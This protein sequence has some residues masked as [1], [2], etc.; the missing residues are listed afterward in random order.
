MTNWSSTLPQ[1]VRTLFPEGV[2]PDPSLVTSSLLTTVTVDNTNLTFSYVQSGS[3]S[4]NR[5]GFAKYNPSLQ[6]VFSTSVQYAFPKI[7]SLN[8]GCLQY[9]DTYTFGPFLNGD[10]VIMFLDA[11]SEST[12]RYWS[13]IDLPGW[14]NPDGYTHSAWVYLTAENMVIFGMEDMSLGDAD[15][16][17]VM[18]Y[19]SYQGAASFGQVA[20]YTNGAIQ[21]C[22]SNTAVSANS[23]AEL[24][25]TQWGLLEPTVATQSCLSFLSIPSG[26]TWASDSDPAAHAAITQLGS[27]QWTYSAATCFLLSTGSATG[28]GYTASGAACDPTLYS[29]KTLANSAGGLCYNAAC[30]SRYVLRGADLG[31]SCTARGVCSSTET[32]TV[33]STIPVNSS[34]VVDFPGSYSVYIP[35]PSGTVN[36]STTIQI[37]AGKPEVDIFVLL[38]LTTATTVPGIANSFT[39]ILS[40]LNGHGLNANVGL[41]IYTP[42]SSA[43]YYVVNSNYTLTGDLQA[44]NAWSRANIATATWQATCPAVGVG[45]SP[46]YSAM[47]SILD[48]ARGLNWRPDAFHLMWVVSSCSFDETMDMRQAVINTG[49]MPLFT[50]P[51]ANDYPSGWDLNAPYSAPYSLR[52]KAGSSKTTFQSDVFRDIMSDDTA[53][54]GPQLIASLWALAFPYVVS[55]PNG[56]ITNLPT[57]P[58]WIGDPRSISVNYTVAWPNGMVPDQSVTSYHSTIRMIGRKVTTI[59]INFNHFPVLSDI[60]MPINAGTNKTINFNP[61]DSDGNLVGLVVVSLP[62]KGV[63]YRPDTGAAITAAGTALPYGMNSLIYYAYPRT[64]GPDTWHMGARD[65]CSIVYAN[66]TMIISY[67]NTP[68][69]AID[70]SITMLEDSLATGTNGLIDFSSHISDLD[71]PA[72]GQTLQVFLSSLPSP[73]NYGSLTTWSASGAGTAIT[74]LGAVANQ[75]R[76]VLNLP[77]GFGSASFYYKVNDGIADSN[78]AKVTINIVHVNHAPVLNI[79][80]TQFNVDS[81]STANVA[82]TASITDSDGSLDT[83]NLYAVWS[84]VTTF[85]VQTAD[86]TIPASPSPTDASPF[87]MYN[88]AYGPSSG[89]TFP[90]PGLVW[91]H[92]TATQTQ[93]VTFQA[94]DNSGA[95]SNNVTVYFSVTVVSAPSSTPVAATPNP[96]TWTLRPQDA[97]PSGFT[98]SQ[99][100]S[101]NLLDFAATDIDAGEYQTLIFTLQSKSSNGDV[102]LVSQTSPSS[103]ISLSAGTDFSDPLNTATYVPLNSSALTSFFRFSYVP[104]PTFYG[105]DQFVVVVRDSTNLYAST[106]ANVTVQVVRLDT[107]PLSSNSYMRGDE[108]AIVMTSIPLFSTNSPSNPVQLQLLSSSF[109][110]L[111]SLNSGLATPWTPGQNTTLTTSGFVSVY[112]QGLIGMFSPNATV[113]IGSFTYRVLEPETADSAV[114]PTYTCQ[115]Y[116]NHVNHPPTSSNVAYTVKKRTV[117]QIVLPAMDPDADDTP[118]TITAVLK[119]IAS[120]SQGTFYLDAGLTQVI[121]NNFISS[122]VTA[123]SLGTART[124]YYVSNTAYSVP[125]NQP[126]ARFTFIVVDQHGLPSESTYTGAITVLPAGDA[127]VYGGLLDVT[128]AQ[129]M[130]VSMALNVGVTT[131]TGVAA[132][133]TIQTLPGRG[134]L[135]ACD[136]SSI[137]CTAVSSSQLPLT[138]TSSNGRVIFLPRAYDWDQNFTSFNFALTDSSNPAAVSVWTMR[139]HVIH[140]NKNPFIE[141]SNFLTTSQTTA[142]IVVNES[143][144]HTFTWKTYDQDSLP[145]VLLTSLRISFYTSQGFTLYSCTG[146][147]A[148]WAVD[149]ECVFNPSV[150]IG[151]RTAFSKNAKQVIGSYST[152]S[153][154]CPDFPTLKAKYGAIDSNCEAHFKMAFVPTPG[155]SFTPYISINFNAVDDYGAESQTISALIFV[156]RMNQPPTLYTPPLVLGSSGV[157]NP[158]IRNTDQQSAQFNSPVIVGD[159][160][161]FGNAELLTVS[162]NQGYAGALFWPDIAPCWAD[163]S[164]NAQVWYCKDTIPSFNQWLSDLRF[165]VDSGNRA[166]LTFTFN[167]LGYSSDWKPSPNITVSSQTSIRLYAAITAPKGNSSTLAISVGIAAGAGLILLGALGFIL[168]RAVSPPKD[169]YFSDAIAPLNSSPTSPLYQA[170]NETHENALYKSKV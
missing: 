54:G 136:A 66:A 85:T 145:S 39:A 81:T 106:V 45:R 156:K 70:F 110:G 8:G 134:T 144:S 57:S 117:L 89:T 160:D 69:V 80:I 32:G 91:N 87:A 5:L 150:P 50:Y 130:P 27:T 19:L 20:P 92:N 34:N 43:P 10:L 61:S 11:D 90:V 76:F 78:L 152:V 107:P 95:K 37:P 56:F 62:L 42:I 94:R 60:T 155:S 100:S 148:N 163:P 139:I 38:D 138:L 3:G 26:W 33:I 147:P 119:S 41:A 63:L 17:D 164:P 113:P 143:T 167:D 77:S 126:L 29:I 4:T 84:S 158:F 102:R 99:G 71:N 149:A 13:Y 68:P 9:G 22:N 133:A 24:N 83:V 48:P 82:I 109:G 170:Q 105:T 79:P 28:V 159:V 74:S 153:S 129:E 135:F 124:M 101:L 154:S 12:A 49:V 25:C 15:Y 86:Q 103:Y 116:L 30:S 65:G 162:V 36:L 51:Y 112:A 7:N 59:T 128:T 123:G 98:I 64:S 46:V 2:H 52:Y 16:N 137:N 14:V 53:V 127:P 104:N 132:V 120:G 165:R 73:S 115:I 75:T 40:Q 6:T 97:N 142:G 55:D 125:S 1:T 166:D 146:T 21:V 121:D 151:D 44:L 131:E 111:I 168:R 141:A 118:P 23:Y 58:A 161:A 140:V 96:P 35:S 157:S 93:A 47:A 31:A 169:D 108:Q 67:V 18:F 114:G 122:S 88:A 72:M